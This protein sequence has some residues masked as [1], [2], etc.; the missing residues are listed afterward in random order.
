[1]PRLTSRHA[2]P[3]QIREALSKHAVRV[4][5]LFREWDDDESGSVSKK[6]FRQAMNLLGLDVPRSEMDLLFDSWDADHSGSIEHKEL[7]KL[8]R[9]GVS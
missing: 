8:L 2:C 1:V 5:D 7:N 6:E 9:R 3:R 4:I